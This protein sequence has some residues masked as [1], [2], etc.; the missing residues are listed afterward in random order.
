MQ[1]RFRPTDGPDWLP[2][3]EVLEDRLTSALDYPFRSMLEYGEGRSLSGRLDP[4]ERSAIADILGPE[5]VPHTS[6][7]GD[8]HLWNFVAL[9]SGAYRLIDWEYF[10]ED[11][12]FV[13]DYLDFHVAASYMTGNGSWLPA[14]SMVTE[15]HPVFRGYPTGPPYP[16]APLP[17]IIS[18]SRSIRSFV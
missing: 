7:H 10:D 8:M 18:S 14:L 2:V 9:G 1:W 15:D 6:L 13:Y 5:S 12:S 3:R 17:S 16:R 4:G 11:G